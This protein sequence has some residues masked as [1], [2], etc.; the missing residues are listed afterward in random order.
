MKHF[1]FFSFAFLFGYGVFSQTFSDISCKKEDG[2]QTYS[3]ALNAKSF[4]ELSL[5][6]NTASFVAKTSTQEVFNET[7]HFAQQHKGFNTKLLYNQKLR[8]G[9]FFIEAYDDMSLG[10]KVYK[11]I[12]DKIS[13]ISFL[14]FAA[15]T[16][17]NGERMNYNNILPYISIINSGART[18]M[19]FNTP[20]FV[21]NPNQSNEE[22]LNS[23]DYYFELYSLGFVIK[24]YN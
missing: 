13:E 7:I 21:L 12:G 18:L 11:I 14:P 8:T 9:F 22:I 24:K 16:S 4:L 5:Q 10:A 1:L 3:I 20:L 23:K 15:Y 2:I 19:F 6:E 17:E